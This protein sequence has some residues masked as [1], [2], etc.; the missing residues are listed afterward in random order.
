MVEEQSFVENAY[1][2]AYLDAHEAMN[3]AMKR[4]PNISPDKMLAI[5]S[6][7]KQRAMENQGQ[8]RVPFPDISYGEFVMMSIRS[9]FSKI[10]RLGR[11]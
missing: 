9:M 6:K 8:Q 1:V 5:A 3:E 2:K 10:F 11:R 7:G 4:D